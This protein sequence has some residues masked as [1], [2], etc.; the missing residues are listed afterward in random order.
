MKK[1]SEKQSQFFNFEIFQF[2][3]RAS[4]WI[5]QKIYHK[6]QFT[7]IIDDV[8][9]L[10]PPKKISKINFSIS[11]SL[12]TQISSFGIDK[13]PH[14]SHSSWRISCKP[15]ITLFIATFLLSCF[16]WRFSNDIHVF[17]GTVAISRAPCLVYPLYSSFIT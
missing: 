12:F 17:S 15:Y 6:F 4:K 3:F 2:F 9:K 8:I 1:Q 11:F 14:A 7:A 16:N 5:F 10:Q 13:S